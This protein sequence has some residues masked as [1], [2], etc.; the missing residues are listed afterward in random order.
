MYTKW[1]QLQRLSDDVGP[2]Q[3]SATVAKFCCNTGDAEEKEMPPS[4]PCCTKKL[5]A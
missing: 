2:V 3:S 5:Q 1:L 4:W